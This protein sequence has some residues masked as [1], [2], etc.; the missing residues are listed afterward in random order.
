MVY[1]RIRYHDSSHDGQG[2][3]H[4]VETKGLVRYPLKLEREP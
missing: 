4:D 1:P 2:A 3:S